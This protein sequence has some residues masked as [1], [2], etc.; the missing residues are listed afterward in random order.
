MSFKYNCLDLLTEVRNGDVAV[1]TYACL[2]DGTKLEE[3]DSAGAGRAYV[4]S[5][6]LEKKVLTALK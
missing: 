1:A 2:A 4:G 3:V 5:L 6:I